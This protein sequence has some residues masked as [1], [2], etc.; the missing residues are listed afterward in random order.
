MP[1]RL[2]GF[3]PFVFLLLAGCT[4]SPL[5]PGKASAVPRDRISAPDMLQ[6]GPGRNIAVAI[7]R[8]G[9]FTGGAMGCELQ[10]DGKKIA[11][12]SV[13]E[14]ITIYLSPGEHKIRLWSEFFGEFKATETMTAGTPQNFRIWVAG[15]DGFRIVRS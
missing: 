4:T 15:Q 13:A 10:V 2:A 3:L 6:P 14:T 9:G 12:F 7:T 1:T 11:K 8:D 5:P